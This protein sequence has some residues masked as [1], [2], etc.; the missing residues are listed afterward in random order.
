MAENVLDRLKKLDAEREKLIADAKA[1]L[2]KKAEE[3]VEELNSLGFQYEL[4]ERGAKRTTAPRAGGT[5]SRRGGMRDTIL[6]ALK[7]QPLSRADLMQKLGAT[8]DKSK[9]GSIS[10]AL[11]QMKKAGQLHQVDG[12]WANAG[13]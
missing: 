6:D 11:S 13:A 10:N 5:R 9:E 3:A 2:L 12:K 1:T 8:G 7:E 4:S